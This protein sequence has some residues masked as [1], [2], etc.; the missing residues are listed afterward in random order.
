MPSNWRQPPV[1]D[2]ALVH[3]IAPLHRRYLSERNSFRT[4]R[5]ALPLIVTGTVQL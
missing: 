5:Y 4:A 1:E 3:G 2:A